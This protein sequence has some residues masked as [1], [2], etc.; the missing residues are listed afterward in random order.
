M[1]SW[2]S[3]SPHFTLPPQRQCN[4]REEPLHV[5]QHAPHGRTLY[6]GLG[7]QSPGNNAHS[8]RYASRASWILGL[9]GCY[10]SQ[11]GPSPRPRLRYQ[12]FSCLRRR[13]GVCTNHPATAPTHPPVDHHPTSC[14]LIQ[15]VPRRQPNLCAHHP[16]RANLQVGTK[17]DRTIPRLPHPQ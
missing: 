10:R 4:Q 3:A 9:Y 7:R 13:S 5:E 1:L 14:G 11:T 16:S 15:L 8:Q 12:P 17:V 2:D 6:Q